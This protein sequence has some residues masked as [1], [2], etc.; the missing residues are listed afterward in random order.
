MAKQRSAGDLYHS[1]AFDRRIEIDQGDGN[2]VGEW[3]Q[4]FRCRAGVI[5]LRGGESVMAGRLQGQHSQIV[6]V[7]ASSVSMEATTEWQARDL[8]TGVAY[9]IREIT[10]SDDRMWLDFLCQSGVAT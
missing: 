5:N 3:Q 9:N 8:R 1:Y 7:R 2:T 10:R 6:F 4:K